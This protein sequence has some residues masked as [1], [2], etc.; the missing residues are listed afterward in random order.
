ML[1][2]L[3]PA[4]SVES[5]RAAVQNGADAVY[6]GYGDF[7]ARR[8]AKNFTQEDYAWALSYC[9]ERGVK[10]YLTLNTLL[11]DRELPAAAALAAQASALGTDAVLVQDLGVLR[12]VRQAAPDLP[13]HASTQMTVHDLPGVLACA[14]LGMTR[15]VLSRELPAEEIA[16]ICQNSPVEIEVF[17]HGAMCM[18]YSG[19]CFFSAVVGERSGNRG[20]CAQP[21]RL[22]YG[23]GRRA[24]GC[25]LSL[26]DMS[27]AGHLREL[28]KMGVKCVKL[29][30]RMKRPEY[31]AVVTGVYSRAIREDREPTAEEMSA[32]EAAFSRQ[33]FTQDYFL[34]RPGPGMFGVREDAGEPKELYAQ[35]RETYEGRE[36]P[37]VGVD[38]F[39][40]VQAGEPVRVAVRDPDGRVAAAVGA[41][42]ERA[43][44]KALTAEQIGKQLART[45]GTPYLCR[46]V[47]TKLDDALAVPLAALNALRREVLEDLS[48]QRAAPPSRRTGEFHAGVRYDEPKTP[49]A[50]TVSVRRA[51]QV[52]EE[53][54]RLGPA[55]LYV[56][57]GELSAHPETAELAHRYKVA[58]GAIV[59]RVVWD[60]EWPAVKGQLRACRDLGAADALLGS[61]GAVAPAAEL[62]YALRADFGLPVFNS[63]AMK[64]LKHL[65]FAAAT[66]SFELQFSQIR[67][68]SKV[69]PLEAVV[70]GRLPLMLTEND[71]L[72]DKDGDSVLLTD[73]KGVRFPVVRAPGGRSEILNA[74]TLFVADKPEYRRVGLTWARLAF[75]TET[76]EEC[77]RALERY[78]GLNDWKP[79]S[80]TK[81]L[82]YRGV[83]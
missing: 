33:G 22:K 61:Y 25:P 10:V 14:K 23:W 45:G 62:G 48:A 56:P 31:V 59:P 19:Q 16:Y 80:F 32:L 9:H 12:A 57:A 46:D 60:R 26:K 53:L 79:K 72:A 81:G 27:L 50:L 15:V 8:N 21:C 64:E 37:R 54:L 78:Q 58:L 69:L 3:A 13:V 39:C 35:A 17:A 30:G 74:Q 2:L 47:K 65:G 20:L 77:V 6:L 67:D 42:P 49:P 18:S 70:Y 44:N 41:V 82:Y 66:A 4:G 73:R 71:L 1:E 7:N 52:T 11:T 76:P 34:D 75:T 43:L 28:R 29:E 36:A 38:F 83:E 40:A 68:L 5:V 63:Q 51:D 55:L 24:D